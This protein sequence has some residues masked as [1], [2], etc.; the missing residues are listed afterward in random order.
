MIVTFGNC[1][2]VCLLFYALDTNLEHVH[3]N[4]RLIISE[5]T[6]VEFHIVFCKF[7]IFEIKNIGAF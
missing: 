3:K 1:A 5:Q 7:W 4:R 2:D 6:F